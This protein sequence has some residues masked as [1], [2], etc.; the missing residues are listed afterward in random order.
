MTPRR[1]QLI[2]LA[3]GLIFVAFGLFFLL[4]TPQFSIGPFRWAIGLPLLVVGVAN[5]LLAPR[6]LRETLPPDAAFAPLDAQGRPVSGSALVQRI[7]VTLDQEL[8]DT[9]H[10]IETAPD[11]VRVAFDS[12]VYRRPGTLSLREFGWRTTLTATGPTSFG[13]LD[14]EANRA[15]GVGWVR[16]SQTG[17]LRWGAATR[18]SIGGDGTVT[19]SGVST[20]PVSAAVKAAL[21]SAGA[22]Q[23]MP[24][25]ALV[26]IVNAAL[27]VLIAIG[28][29]VAAA[30]L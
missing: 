14:Q 25:M 29:A 27:G 23:S 4:G 21:A 6:F 15:A 11:A 3:L 1:A 2:T 7:A 18:T 5:L 16:A 26:G 17:G 30:L 20:S 10:R 22:T 13:R 9:P 12:G 8:R 24:T 19:R 28:A